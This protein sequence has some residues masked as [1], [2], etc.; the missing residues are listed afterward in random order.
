MDDDGVSRQ[1]PSENGGCALPRRDD[2][3]DALR[4]ARELS[5]RRSALPGR[6]RPGV[7]KPWAAIRR[8][9]RGNGYS[10]AELNAL[11]DTIENILPAS[12]RQW[13]LIHARHARKWPTQGHNV[14]GLKRKFAGLRKKGP[15]T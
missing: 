14:E 11:L 6:K 13:E 1:E 12:S 4:I 9:G 2:S 7:S 8:N 10:E 15:S 5:R 3:Q